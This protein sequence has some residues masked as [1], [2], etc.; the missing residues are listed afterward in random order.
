V[1]RCIGGILPGVTL[2]QLDLKELRAIS[3]AFAEEK[4]PK[5]SGDYELVQRIFLLNRA[6]CWGNYPRFSPSDVWLCDPNVK[7]A[8]YYCTSRS[9]TNSD[10]RHGMFLA[11][12][13]VYAA[14]MR[15]EYVRKYET[16][17]R[18]GSVVAEKTVITVL[19]HCAEKRRPA[20]KRK[21]RFTRRNVFSTVVS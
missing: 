11:V 5:A 7:N 17:A 14:I 6:V 16:G 19:V 3:M 4:V 15:V 12:L 20:R 1:S 10:S 8:S 9:I 21:L 2:N 13:C 18:K